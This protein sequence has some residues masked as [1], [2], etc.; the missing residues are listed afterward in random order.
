MT[1]INGI[2]I[3][4]AFSL[5]LTFGWAE[6]ITISASL[7][8]NNTTLNDILS[9]TVDIEGTNKI[10]DLPEPQGKN[11]MIVNGPFQSSNFQFINGKMSSNISFTWQ[12]QPKAEGELTVNGFSVQY[13]KKKY[14]ANR[15][16][17]TVSKEDILLETR[18]INLA[19]HSRDR[20]KVPAKAMFSWM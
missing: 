12:L 17:A 7:N 6:D 10:K 20:P 11:F 8:S 14:S 15:V 16:V 5:L 18:I 4:L 2:K 1:K 9:Y 13:K 3:L 19:R